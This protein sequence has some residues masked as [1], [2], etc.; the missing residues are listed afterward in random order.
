MTKVSAELPLYEEIAKAYEVDLDYGE[1]VAYLRA[2]SDDALGALPYSMRARIH[3]Y[4]IEGDLLTYSIDQFDAPRTVIANDTDLRARIIHEY[5]DTPAG[6]HLGREKTF[7]AVSREFYWPHLYK[8]VRNWVRTCE[9]CQRV[10]PSPSSQAP[11][12]SLLIATEAWRSIS[13]DFIFGLAPDSQGRTGILVFV[14]RFSKMSHL[15]PVFAKV[16]AA[17]S[18]HFIDAVYRHHGLPESIIS[19]RDP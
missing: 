5:H 18:S 13:M 4:K 14:D 2:L 19:D 1:I 3:R 10:K 11:L 6:G 17:D 16:T 15:I 12:R 9:I 7:A 8:W